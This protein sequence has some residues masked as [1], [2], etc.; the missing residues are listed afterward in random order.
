MMSRR[1]RPSARTIRTAPT[2]PCVPVDRDGAPVPRSGPP[3]AGPVTGNGSCTSVEGGSERSTGSPRGPRS[4][5]PIDRRAGRASLAVVGGDPAGASLALARLPRRPGSTGFYDHF[6][7]QAVGLP[8]GP[9]GDPLPGRQHGRARR[10]LATSRTSC[11]S[12]RRDGVAARP[13]AVPAA[14]GASSCCRS[15]RCGAWRPTT[16][17]LFT[18]LA[19]RRRRARLVDARAAR[20]SG[21]PSGRATTV[22]FAFGTVFWYAAQLA[23]TWYQAHIVAVGLH[24]PG[25]RARPRRATRRPGPTSPMPTMPTVPPTDACG[26]GARSG[27][28]RLAIDRRQFVAGLLFGLACTARLTVLFAAP[29]FVLVGAGGSWLAARLVGR[30]RRARSRSAC[31]WP[32][33]S[34][35]PASSSTRPTSTCTSSRRAATRASAITPTGPSRT[36]RYLPQNLGIMLLRAARHP[37]GHAARRAR[38]RRDARVHGPGAARGLF[39]LGCPLAVPRDI[40]MSLLLT[41]PAF[42]LAIPALRRFGRSRLVTGAPSRSSLVVVVNLMHFSQGWVQ[43]G[44]RFSNDFVPFALLLVALGIERLVGRRRRWAMPLAMG[45]VVALGRHQCLGR[46]LGHAPR[47]VSRAESAAAAVPRAPSRRRPLAIARRRRRR[48]RSA[49]A[50]CPGSASGTPA[51]SRRSARSS[52]RPTRPASRPTCS[53]AGSRRSLLQP[54]RRAG[55][56][57]EPV[58][59]DLPSASRRRSRSTSS[60]RLTRSTVLGVAGGPRAGR[61]PIVWAIGTHAEAHALHLRSSRSCC[62]LLVALGGRPPGSRAR[63]GALHRGRGRL[64]AGRRQPLADP[65]PGARGSRCSSSPSSRGSCAGRGFVA[66]CAAVARR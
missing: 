43:F 40:G 47:M 11:R 44:Y 50:A 59:G 24:A 38:R 36:P 61:S 13:P 39:D 56:P 60:G 5:R 6:V 65:A 10:Q 63:T 31:S 7:W 37:P 23:T 45:L 27:A 22:F 17:A 55:V 25:G 29:F 57:D 46:R 8:R 53:S 51:S 20:R 32:T 4:D 9:G 16:S 49:G 28:T 35:R 66:A 30:A 42:L 58:R 41:S 1:A 33:T 52:A 34:S 26:R 21:R 3:D 54:V 62:R 2:A 14:A 15:W 64:R 19:A 48:R 18:I 12:R